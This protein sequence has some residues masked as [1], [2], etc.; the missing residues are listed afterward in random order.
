MQQLVRDTWRH[1]SWPEAY[2]S[3]DSNR[4]FLALFDPF[5]AVDR[6]DTVIKR[7]ILREIHSRSNDAAT[8]R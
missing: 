4:V 3:M 7:P 2:H 8:V 1:M 5:M 6:L